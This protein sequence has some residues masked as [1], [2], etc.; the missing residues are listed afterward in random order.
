MEDGRLFCSGQ[1]EYGLLGRGERK[2]QNCNVVNLE[3]NTRKIF[4]VPVPDKVTDI[5]VGRKHA[6]ALTV[7]GEVYAW[8]K[9]NGG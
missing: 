6:L 3:A 7:Y 9:N 4:R 1:S 8:G 2:S 5:K